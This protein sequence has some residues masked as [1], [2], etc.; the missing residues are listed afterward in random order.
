VKKSFIR[1]FQVKPPRFEQQLGH[2]IV[3]VFSHIHPQN[4]NPSIFGITKVLKM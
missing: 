3:Y 4:K 2:E 1:I